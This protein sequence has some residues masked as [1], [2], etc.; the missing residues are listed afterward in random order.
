MSD[1]INRETQSAVIDPIHHL[2]NKSSVF[3]AATVEVAHGATEKHG[4]SLLPASQSFSPSI[5]WL[6][7]F[8]YFFITSSQRC[9]FK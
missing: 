2:S 3:E 8:H 9:S 4:C 5:F 6:A 1:T 7:W